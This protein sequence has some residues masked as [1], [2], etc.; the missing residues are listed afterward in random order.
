MW[1][2]DVGEKGQHFSCMTTRTKY[3]QQ[4]VVR[5][6]CRR[7]HSAERKKIEDRMLNKERQSASTEDSVKTRR[8]GSEESVKEK[9]KEE[10]E[11]GSH[12]TSLRFD[13]LSPH[14]H[15]SSLQV[16]R[17]GFT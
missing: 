7:R 4:M 11:G 10:E 9:N 8:E 14:L 17:M 6:W 15:I 2:V 1:M 13:G 16:W 3:N 12:S 5:Q